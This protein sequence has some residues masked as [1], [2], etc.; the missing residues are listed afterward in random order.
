VGVWIGNWIYW[1]LPFLNYNL[2]WRYRQFT[3]SAVHYTH[4]LSLLSLLALHPFSGTSFQR[5]TFPFLNSRTVPV[6]QPQ[7]LLTRSSLTG[8]L[9]EPPPLVAVYVLQ[10]SI[11][12]LSC[13]VMPRN[14]NSF[15]FE[16]SVFKD[17]IEAKVILRPTVSRPVSPGIRPPSGAHDL[18]IFFR[19]LQVWC[20]VP[21]SLMRGRACNLQLLLGLAIAVP[22]E[23][24][25]RG[26]HNQVLFFGI[27]RFPQLRRPGSR[28]YFRQEQG[29]PVINPGNKFV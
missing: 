16:C 11:C 19:Q 1:T 6:P 15:D 3:Q 7:Q 28:V 12:Y 13:F 18:E 9:L 20:C 8:T 26:A 29:S 10:Y 24:A 17:K 14:N 25:F 4:V 22:L 2:F 27:L 5:Q 21:P 23:S